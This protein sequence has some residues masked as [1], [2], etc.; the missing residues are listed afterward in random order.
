MY[1]WLTEH[2]IPL[3]IWLRDFVDLLTT[4]GQSFFDFV[5]LVLG[6]LIGGFTAALLWVPPLLLIALF[7]LG[8]WWMHRSIGLVVF[9]VGA[10]LL[11]TNLGYWNATME[12]LSSSSAPRWC[13]SSS[14][15]P[16]A[17]PP[18]TGPGSTPGSGRSSI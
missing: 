7:A 4:H 14:A 3:G 13:A 17:S 1:D 11:V 18:R 2:K 10:L 5:S 8:A 9:I 12:T 6:G 15:C 16:S